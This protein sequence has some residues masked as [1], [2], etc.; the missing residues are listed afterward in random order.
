M[1]A[2]E[3]N[4]KAVIRTHKSGLI[5]S[6]FTTLVSYGWKSGPN[7]SEKSCRTIFSEIID[8]LM[9]DLKNSGASGSSSHLSRYYVQKFQKESGVRRDFH[10]QLLL[11]GVSRV[12]LNHFLFQAALPFSM[13]FQKQF[14]E[15]QNIFDHTLIALS[16]WWGELYQDLSKRDKSLIN[17][18]SLVKNGIQQQL[19][20]IYQ[21]FKESP[22]G[23]A[24]C[25]LNLNVLLWNRMASRLTGF[26]QNHIIKNS[27]MSVFTP[28]SQEKLSRKIQDN[29]RG[30][31]RLQLT[32]QNKH[33]YSFPCVVSIQRM[34]YAQP[35]GIAYIISF[36]DLRDEKNIQFQTQ[37]I[38]QLKA[39]GRLSGAIM[40]DIRN[41]VNS[42][43]L[44]VEALQQVL[45]Q[46]E[47]MSP[48]V[49]ELL[50]GILHG[51]DRLKLILDQYLGYSRLTEMNPELLNISE[52]TEDLLR[53]RSAEISS[54][55]IRLVFKPAK[56][57]V[58]INGDWIQLKR[59]FLNLFENSVQAVPE[60]GKIEIKIHQ[61]NKRA[62][63]TIRDNGP[64]I[65]P[66][67]RSKIYEPF[68]STKVSGTG[69]GLYI[70]R[71]IVRG[72]NGRVYCASSPG[73]GTQF[74][75]SFPAASEARGSGLQL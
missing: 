8:H 16:Q 12:V 58:L 13:D 46:M 43:G 29:S 27:F 1:S 71:E 73:R 23:V 56:S 63:L 24:G 45:E 42:L 36:L 35:K 18:L 21:I 25:D 57:P 62:L 52:K 14:R 5:D 66:E 28:R 33:G 7:L 69:L 9:Q 44:N 17:E 20:L 41:P 60:N 39:L 10:T 34:S 67:Q 47:E 70:V 51:V 37:Q 61:K 6:A 74:T 55:K 53:E 40:H 2:K 68:F 22:V 75:I 59:M 11:L 19:D 3:K 15:I 65:S 4:I 50:Q 32:I 48:D 72:H 30:S 49:G 26:Q 38:S 54:R 64:G 31:A